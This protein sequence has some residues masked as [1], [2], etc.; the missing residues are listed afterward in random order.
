MIKKEK[1]KKSRII[2]KG[3][4]DRSNYQKSY[5]YR[6]EKIYKPL[7]IKK[8][9]RRGAKKR[10]LLILV[11]LQMRLEY[12]ALLQMHPEN[13]ALPPLQVPVCHLL[14]LQLS[15]KSIPIT[16]QSSKMSSTSTL[17]D[18]FSLLSQ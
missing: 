15:L 10:K 8:V 13:L 4:S 7:K 18:F 14:E 2:W 9:Q 11:L 12:L 3:K 5:L 1:E 17:I 16:I 6:G